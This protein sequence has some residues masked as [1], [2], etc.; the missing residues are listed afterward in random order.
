MFYMGSIFSLLRKVR[1]VITFGAGVLVGMSLSVAGYAYATEIIATLS[2]QPIYVDGEQVEM[3]AYAISG[4]NYVRLRDI[5]ESVDFDVSYDATTNSVHIDTTAPY[6]A[7]D[8]EEEISSPVTSVADMVTVTYL[9]A[10]ESKDIYTITLEN[11][12]IEGK[13]SNGK[14][15]TEENI[16]S[17]IAEITEIFPDGM[18]WGSSANDGDIL[19]YSNST[20]CNSYAYMVRDILYGTDCTSLYQHNDLSQIR[21]GDVVHLGNDENNT[22]HWFVATGVGEGSLGVQIYL[23]E[24]NSGGKVAVTSSYLSVLEVYYPDSTIYCFY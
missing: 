12:T 6:F 7:D 10:F 11:E 19:R 4:N 24:G 8:A 16:Q 2:A 1:S 21:A 23:V 20:G 14:E 9:S 5:G 22:G 3:T 17:M 13:L 18:S 15:I